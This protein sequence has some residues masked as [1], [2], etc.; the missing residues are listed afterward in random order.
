MKRY[1]SRK[2]GPLPIRLK[3]GSISVASKGYFKVEDDD[4]LSPDLL[5]K[6]RTQFIEEVDENGRRIV[7]DEA[8]KEPVEESKAESKA[9]SEDEPE[10]EEDSSVDDTEQK[11]DDDSLTSSSEM[12]ESEEE[13][14]DTDDAQIT[15]GIP[16]LKKKKARGEKSKSR[17]GISG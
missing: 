8:K 11:K 3:S 7:P 9:E 2:L 5:T 13:E 4:L 1:R 6:K 16:M 15:E 12:V 17:K 10:P 14:T